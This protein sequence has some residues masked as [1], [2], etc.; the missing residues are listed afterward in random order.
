MRVIVKVLRKRK[1]N[2]EPEK[3]DN[4]NA[5]V[6]WVHSLMQYGLYTQARN[7]YL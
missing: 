6:S 2:D 5:C 3:R 7:I 1:N 4:I